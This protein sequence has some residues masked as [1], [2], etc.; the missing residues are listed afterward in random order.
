MKRLLVVGIFALC[1]HVSAAKAD[2]STIDCNLIQSDNGKLL[3][4]AIKSVD[5]KV[6]RILSLLLTPGQPYPGPGDSYP[7]SYTC[8]IKF[9][10]KSM[11]GFGDSPENARLDTVE[12]CK[13]A[14]YYAS[15]CN[16]ALTGCSVDSPSPTG[17]YSCSISFGSRV[18]NGLGVSKT[19]ARSEVMNICKSSGYY[20][21]DCHKSFSSCRVV[22][23]YQ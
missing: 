20:A 3:C 23:H 9:G 7:V 16:K 1:A 21:S 17:H 22:T 5:R 15:D 6:D 13:G 2:T 14:G 19:L 11:E 12:F 8:K 10:S 18:F 4:Q